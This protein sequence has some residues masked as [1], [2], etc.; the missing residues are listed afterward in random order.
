M[1]NMKAHTVYMVVRPYSEKKKILMRAA[2]E[3]GVLYI[4]GPHLLESTISYP[5]S[6]SAHHVLVEVKNQEE[7]DQVIMMAACHHYGVGE[8]LFNA[9]SGVGAELSH[10]IERQEDIV[11]SV[12]Q[13]P[14]YTMSDEALIVGDIHGCYGHLRALLRK[15]GFLFVGDE[16]TYYPM[17]LVL[18]GDLVNKGPCSADVIRFV[19]SNL[20]HSDFRVV[21]G[22]HELYIMQHID[23]AKPNAPR[24]FD[25]LTTARTNRMQRN[26]FCEIYKES[27][28]YLVS[29]SRTSAVHH[30]PCDYKYVGK[31][32]PVSI[33]KQ[34]HL[35]SIRGQ[36]NK[37]NTSVDEILYPY[38]NGQPNW[39][40]VV[41]GHVT[42]NRPLL[43]NNRAMIDTGA[44]LGCY[45]TAAHVMGSTC[46][47]ISTES[48]DSARNT[49]RLN[50]I[51]PA[52]QNTRS[53]VRR[54][55]PHQVKA[56]A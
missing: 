52:I 20:G 24:F 35:P 36:A 12:E 19:Y 2:H 11:L 3:V 1:I 32:D 15:A 16:I 6:L 34:I 7:A 28:P 5:G 45:L 43:I 9:E 38:F 53:N 21:L 46:Q 47:F 33:Q 10:L 44:F 26:M 4:K 39:P 55:V 23:D 48:V 22:N 42:T 14:Y 40:L 8:I 54:N 27:V 50:P 17:Q 13:V 41:N 31:S 51:A 49:M 29:R 37:Q 18:N 56:L 25:Y 30:S